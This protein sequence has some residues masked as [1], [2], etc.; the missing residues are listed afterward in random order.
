MKKVR[1]SGLSSLTIAVLCLQPADR[2]RID[3]E[4]P[5]DIDQGFAIGRRWS[6]F[7]W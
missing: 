4:G 5:G 6:W 2:G 3:G 7:S 1:F